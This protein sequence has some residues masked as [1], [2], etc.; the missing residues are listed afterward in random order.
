MW[1]V[2]IALAACLAAA[3]EL[4]PRVVVVNVD[5]P[6]T[7]AS[8]DYVSRAM[9]KAAREEAALVVIELD[10]P[11]GLDP[12]MRAIIKAILASPVP[13]ATYVAPDGARAAS[14]GTYILYASHVAAMAPATNLGAAT[15]VSIGGGDEPAR[16][17]EKKDK[18]KSVP[19]T[20][21]S[22]RSK[23]I[24]DAAAYIRGLASMRGRNADWAERAVREAVS[25]PAA[26]A[27]KLKVI[28]VVARDVSDLLA[29]LDGRKVTVNG[30]DRVLHTAGAQITRVEADWRTR[31]L[32][33]VTN[34]SVAVILMMIGVYGLLFEF[35]NPGFV[36]PGVLGGICLL[37][38][39][40]ALQLLP[41]NYAG[42]ALILLGIAFLVG[43][44]FMPSFG[45]LGV[46]GVAAIAIGM[47]VLVDPETAPGL[48]I[49]LSFV[50][51]FTV[52]MSALVFATAWFALEVRRRPVV[53]G[54]EELRGA[55]GVMLEDC[56]REGWARVHGETWRVKSAEPLRAGEHVRVKSIA[57]LLL[58]VEKTGV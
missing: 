30:V 24:N 43:E 44:A 47:V 46:G 23:A 17:D 19:T 37:V 38:G 25:L 10:T 39:L 18:G 50:A 48:A 27:L 16:A 54:R 9:S 58:T 11:G 51:G 5:G 35:M 40:Y 15:P 8:A 45:A 52:V 33:I 28:D 22:M 53:S 29:K 20:R 4:A 6:I 3:G 2:L 42:V 1:A 26:E 32:M 21:E 13:V 56:E 12:S 57:G 14:A 31:L 55:E 41:I 7:P 34:P 36:L 49:P